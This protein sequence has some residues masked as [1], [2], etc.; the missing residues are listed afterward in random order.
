[1][2]I[3]NTMHNYNKI[4]KHYFSEEIFFYSAIYHF[5]D[6]R[7]LYNNRNNHSLNYLVL[8]ECFYVAETVLLFFYIYSNYKPDRGPV[9]ML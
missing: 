7:L 9:F 8:I 1:M 2:Y 4:H 6:H 3:Y 5:L